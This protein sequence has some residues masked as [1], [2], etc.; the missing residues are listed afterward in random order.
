MEEK[1]N[2]KRVLNMDF[3]LEMA[4]VRGGVYKALVACTRTGV[5][6]YRG[7]EILDCTAMGIIDS[8]GHLNGSK[9]VSCGSLVVRH[10][11]GRHENGT[12][13]CRGQW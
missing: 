8:R 9:D 6:V 13:L 5:D 11:E 1:N 12:Y 10:L 7:C 2:R 4:A 3:S